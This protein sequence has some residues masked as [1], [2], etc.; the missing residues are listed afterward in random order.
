LLLEELPHEPD[1]LTEDILAEKEVPQPEN[2]P[3]FWITAK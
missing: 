2:T 3:N 1:E